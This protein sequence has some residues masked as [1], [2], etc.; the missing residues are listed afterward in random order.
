MRELRLTPLLTID[1]VLRLAHADQRVV[2]AQ[3][4]RQHCLIAALEGG[5]DQ[6]AP[7]LVTHAADALPKLRLQLYG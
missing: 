6:L 3:H 2:P 5:T 7:F 4:R 1:S